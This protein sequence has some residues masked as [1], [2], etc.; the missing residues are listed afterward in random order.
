VLNR[1]LERV[2][3]AELRVY[4]DEPYSPVYHDGKADQEGG[5]CQEARIADGVGL[6]NDS[7]ASA[8][9]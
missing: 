7:S 5:A 4:D 8:L 6:A 3:T 2:S 9:D 1:G